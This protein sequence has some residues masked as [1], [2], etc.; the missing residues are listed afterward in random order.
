M[1]L[2]G[3]E[4]ASASEARLLAHGEQQLDVDRRALAADVAREREH[5]GDRG[6]VVGAEDALVGVLPHAVDQHRLDRRMRRHRVEVRAQQHRSP[7]L[8]VRRAGRAA[9]LAGG[10]PREQV[11]AVGVR[12]RARVVLVDLHAERAQL[13]D[14]ALGA[15]TLEAGRALDPAQL[16]E[17]AAQVAA[18]ERAD[19]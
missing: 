6:L 18:L 16:G 9:G 1:S 8:A 10:D 11:A 3:V 12:E 19:C 7:L 14:H 13:G 15:A 2:R 17:R 4:R 5:D